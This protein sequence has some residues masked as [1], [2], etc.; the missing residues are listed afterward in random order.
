MDRFYKCIDRCRHALCYDSVFHPHS[1]IFYGT[2]CDFI[3]SHIEL[4]G[5]LIYSSSTGERKTIVM[6]IKTFISC[7]GSV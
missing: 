6:L 2:I 5:T 7:G 1:P 3:F 4:V